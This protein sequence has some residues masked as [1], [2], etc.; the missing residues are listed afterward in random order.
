MIAGAGNYLWLQNCDG[1]LS[2]SKQLV[3]AKFGTIIRAYPEKNSFF[4]KAP[5]YHR[6]NS[7]RK[8]RSAT[9][10]GYLSD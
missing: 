4:F 1:V 3:I 10:S 7:C 6:L 5:R 9:L 8:I 2:S